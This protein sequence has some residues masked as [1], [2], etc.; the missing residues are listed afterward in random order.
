MTSRAEG[1]DCAGTL[2]ACMCMCVCVLHSQAHRDETIG[3]T[4]SGRLRWHLLFTHEYTAHTLCVVIEP[5][6]MNGF[7]CSACCKS[8]K[9]EKTINMSLLQKVDT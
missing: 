8:D 7:A 6:M 3:C 2:C 4:V 9:E 1:N 5:I